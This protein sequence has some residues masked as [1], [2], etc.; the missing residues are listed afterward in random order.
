MVSSN[1]ADL[2]S[3]CYITRPT[4]CTFVTFV[5]RVQRMRV[6]SSVSQKES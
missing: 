6:G 2:V 3:F 4:L 5:T 1:P